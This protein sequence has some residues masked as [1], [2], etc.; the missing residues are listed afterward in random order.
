MDA[1]ARWLA[2]HLWRRLVYWCAL[3]VAVN[4]TTGPYSGEETT[5]VTALDAIKRW[6]M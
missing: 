2:W 5:G 3:R 1:V 6:S 4:A